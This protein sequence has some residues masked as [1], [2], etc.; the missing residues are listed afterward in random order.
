MKKTILVVD[1]SLAVVS[2]VERVLK[3]HGNRV[4]AACNGVEGLA[5]VE[6]EAIDLIF[7]DIEMPVMGGYKFRDELKKDTR[8]RSIPIV[9]ITASIDIDPL[10]WRTILRK[11]FAATDLVQTVASTLS[12][13]SP[14]NCC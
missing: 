10:G 8:Y 1:D 7:T 14:V 9:A 3:E 4:F 11:P 2:F 12:E 6:Q 13:P 5:K